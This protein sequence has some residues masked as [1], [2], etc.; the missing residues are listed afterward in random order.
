MFHNISVKDALKLAFSGKAQLFDMRTEEEYK[1]GHLPT[2][3]FV[4]T[5]RIREHL[6]KCDEF[7]PI[8]YCDYGNASLQLARELSEEGFFVYSI[9]G[10][11]H[12]YEGYVELQKNRVWT[13]EWKEVKKDIF[14]D[15]TTG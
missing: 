5:E 14:L 9:V 11:Y 3:I 15:N 12:A 7:L 10:G 4:K 13:M 1:K 2:A 6:N 8:L